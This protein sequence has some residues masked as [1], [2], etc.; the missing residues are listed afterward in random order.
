MSLLSWNILNP[1]LFSSNSNNYYGFEEGDINAKKVKARMNRI[2]K[3]ILKLNPDILLI[4]ETNP[5]FT[6][7]IAKTAKLNY[8]SEIYGN[9]CDYFGKET[10]LNKFGTQILWSDNYELKWFKSG[11]TKKCSKIG[12]AGSS[13][14]CCLLNDILVL[15]VH[16]KVDWDNEFQTI[17]N[18]SKELKEELCKDFEKIGKTKII[19]GGDFNAG[20]FNNESYRGWHEFLDE[21]KK[22]L[23]P[24]FGNIDELNDNKWTV[25]M[26]DGTKIKI[27]HIITNIPKSFKDILDHKYFDKR[28]LIVD[29]KNG[30]NKTILKKNIILSD[31]LP[32]L[33]KINDSVFIEKF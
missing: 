16:A 4:Q 13:Y 25:K 19:I 12:R 26:G 29:D 3:E 5:E 22:W 15:T 1:N 11:N 17:V 23:E 31:H 18:L 20:L 6:E 21:I 9:A 10:K 27:D 24:I 14:S 33:Y 7:L 2:S 8:K 28:N 32:L 30:F